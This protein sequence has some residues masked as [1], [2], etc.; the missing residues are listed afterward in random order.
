MNKNIILFI[1]TLIMFS[2]CEGLLYCPPTGTLSDATLTTGEG[3]EYLISSA[4]AGLRGPTSKA[5]DCWIPNTNWSYG[6]VRSEIAYKGG[7]G[8]SDGIA[9]H[10]LEISD[11]IFTTEGIL[12]S[13]WFYTYCL[14]SRCHNAIR[15][16]KQLSK[17]EYSSRDVRLG[18]IKVIRVHHYFD[19]MRIFNYVPY[20]DETIEPDDHMKLNNRE[21]SRDQLLEK[22]IKELQDAADLLPEK[23]TEVGRINRRIAKAYEAKLWLYRAYEQNPENNQLASINK[24]YLQNVLDITETLISEGG[25]DLLKDF[26][27]LD[28]VE[29]DNKSESVFEVQYSVSDGTQFGNVNW[30]FILNVPCS[31]PYNGCGFFLPSQNLVNSFR[32]DENGLPLHDT[33]NNKNLMTVA[34]GKSMNVDPRL[35]F[36]V[37]RPGVRWKTYADAPYSDT[38]SRDVPTYGNYSCKRHLVSPDSKDFLAGYPRG[39]SGLNWDI[40]RFADILLWHAEA[41]IEIGRHDEAVEYIN[42]IRN[43][44]KS[45]TY[46]TDWS[47]PTK[48]AA[49]YVINPYV[50]GENCEWTQEYA[51][52]ALRFERKLELAMDGERFFDLVRWG[53]AAQVLNE[54]YYPKEKTLRTYYKD[55]YFT[56]GQD[57]YLPIPENQIRASGGSLKQNLGY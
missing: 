32:T 31:D 13:K 51:R 34:D 10:Y 16:L 56:A 23:Q 43:R 54:E 15:S 3:V 9:I 22:L 47:D 1:V 44:A 35:D 53:I 45:S 39:L 50:P 14:I 37:G 41:L 46:V 21:F 40:I 48:P 6:D 28:L 57:E 52:K 12:D 36:I 33:Y 25:Y 11:G 7:S 8:I 29:Y 27:H 19:M 5:E 18:E 55:A 26:Q 2:A 20:F 17:D 49:N 24:E 38:W 4:Y 42:R 30:S